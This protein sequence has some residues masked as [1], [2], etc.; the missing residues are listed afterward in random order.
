MDFNNAGPSFLRMHLMKN[1]I[2]ELDNESSNS[3]VQNFTYKASLPNINPYFFQK[4]K[5]DPK[6]TEYTD[7]DMI[8]LQQKID[9]SN[10]TEKAKLMMD[11]LRKMLPERYPKV[12]LAKMERLRAT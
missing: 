7:S 4:Y 10:S 2:H 12:N 5:G 1:P 8:K 11:K 3:I 6:E 9:R